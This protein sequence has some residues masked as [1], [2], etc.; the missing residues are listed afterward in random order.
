LV[1]EGPGLGAPPLDATHG[2]ALHAAIERV[3]PLL[4]LFPAGGAGTQL[5]PALAV[6]MG[7]AFAATADLEVSVS[8]LPLQDSVGRLC[9]RRWRRDLTSYRRLDPVEL[10]RPVIATLGVYGPPRAEGTAAVEVQV[11]DCPPPPAARIVELESVPDEDAAVPLARALVVVGPTVAPDITAKL[12]AAAPAGVAV[13]ELA[14]VSPAALAANTPAAVLGV[15]APA[16]VA[17]PS[18]RTRIGVVVGPAADAAAFGRSDVVWRAA[19]ARAWD[20]LCATLP[21][22]VR[23]GGAS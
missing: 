19:D 2:P 10:E 17:S 23:D 11:I 8:P 1:C 18:P 12:V 6:R 16:H 3:P 13:V 22:L 4:V 9:L 15:E 7:A 14:R 20:E 5:G 21:A